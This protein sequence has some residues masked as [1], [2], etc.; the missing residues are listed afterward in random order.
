[1]PAP[2]E[3]IVTP[4]PRPEIASDRYREIEANRAAD[5]KSGTRRKEDHSRIV[6]R[7][8]DHAWIDGHDRNVRPS[9][10]HDLAVRTQVTEALRL[11]A[12]PLRCLHH[13]LLL[14]QERI[15]NLRGPIHIGSH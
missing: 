11:L 12:F 7:Y 4:S 5:E 13:I 3:T 1:M 15:S 9:A 2:V 6:V 8:E 14:H 10:D